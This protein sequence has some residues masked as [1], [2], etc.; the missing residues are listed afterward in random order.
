MAHPTALLVGAPG[1]EAAA[2][3][4]LFEHSHLSRGECQ[5]AFSRLQA[6]G[7]PELVH[8]AFRHVEGELRAGGWALQ[9][10]TA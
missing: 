10:A 6:G 7:E 2:V 5:E 3:E 4:C 8:I 9:D 1:E